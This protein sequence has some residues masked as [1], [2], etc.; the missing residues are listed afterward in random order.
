MAERVY[1][2]RE[3]DEMR[4]AVRCLAKFGRHW[5]F[6]KRVRRFPAEVTDAEIEERLRTYMQHGISPEELT[7]EAETVWDENQA[8][9]AAAKVASG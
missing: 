2:V 3:I 8:M 4:C 9:R 6:H 5:H 1:S 7:A